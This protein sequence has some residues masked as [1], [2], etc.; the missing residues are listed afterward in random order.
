MKTITAIQHTTT[1]LMLDL[2]ERQAALFPDAI[3]VVCAG[4]QLTYRELDRRANQLAHQLQKMS[5]KPETLVGICTTRSLEM[6]VSILGV[7][8]A[9]GAYVPL[10][11]SYPKDRISFILEDSQA[12]VVVTESA[13][14]SYFSGQ[15]IQMVFLDTDR[16]QIAENCSHMPVRHLLPENLAYV[17]YTSGSTGKPKGVM[18]GHASLAHFVRIASLALDVTSQDVYIQTASIAYALSIRQ[19]MIPLAQGATIIIATTE[20]MRDPLLMFQLVKSRN[21][22][23]MDMVPSF[24]RTCIQRLAELPAEEAR[25]L[26]QNSLRRIVSIG[27][28]LLSDLPVEWSSRFGNKT[29]LVNIFGQTETTGVVATY[30]IPTKPPGRI[31]IVPIGRCVSDTRLYLLDS[32]LKPVPPGEQGELCVSNPCLA[33]GYLNRPEL[34]AEKFIPNP[35][36]DG[37]NDRL[38]RTGDMAQMREDGN[39]QFLGRGDHQVKIRGQRLELGEVEALIREY[40]AVRECV[41]TARGDHPDDKYLA[42]YVV[43]QLEQAVDISGL[44]NFMRRKAPAYMVPSAFV[45]LNSIP[46]TPNGKINRLALPDPATIVNRPILKDAPAGPRNQIEQAIADIWKELL[47]T[48]KVGRDDNFFDLGGHSLAVVRLFSRVEQNFGVRLPPAIILQ[49]PT[50]AQIAEL[51]TNLHGNVPQWKILVPIQPYGDKPPFF[52]VHAVDGG[53]LF[54][55]NIVSHL[56]KDQ[57][58]Y[59]LQARGS[60]GIQSPLNCISEMA[61]LYISEIRKAQPYGPYYI[62]GY[63]LGGEIAFEISQQLFRQGEKVSLLVLF[64]TLNPNRTIRPVVSVSEGKLVPEFDQQSQPEHRNVLIRKLKGHYLRLSLLSPKDRM[65]Y[66]INQIQVRFNRALTTVL[67]KIF[68][69]LKLRLPNFLILRYLQKSHSEALINYIPSVY[70]GKITLFRAT[71]TVQK[72]PAD[73][74]MGWGPL[75]AGGMEVHYFDAPH[76]I[77]NEPYAKDVAQKLNECLIAARCE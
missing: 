26:M 41:V 73:S 38:Y 44:R 71:T 69:S 24:W 15:Q 13:F 3:A 67:V 14:C 17:I 2:F 7:L 74:P 76:M 28:P 49:A 25:A 30:P 68:Q 31:G 34:T 20:E 10:D 35:F 70:P 45:V 60:D 8:K 63:S 29:R 19:L 64:D 27:E 9:G 36:G 39:I 11:P 75:A 54:W 33:R 62:G 55:R 1:E 65:A 72:H 59:A 40:S 43:P 16:D 52:G 5:V 77:V 61:A 51:I 56:P 6:V 22:T 66:L 46:R 32:N 37:F 57:P 42:A 53:V 18:I 58:F 12:L 4:Q 21:I 23:L 47:K 48:D 50:I